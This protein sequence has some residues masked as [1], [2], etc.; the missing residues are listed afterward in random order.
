MSLQKLYSYARLV[1]FI[2]AFILIHGC[3]TIVYRSIPLKDIARTGGDYAVGTQYFY[4]VDST[5]SM[6]LDDDIA[7][8]RE[9]S[10]KIWYPA[11][12]SQLRE[13][14]PYVN[15]Q[16]LISEALSVRLGV[17]KAL[18]KRAGGVECNSWLDAVPVRGRFPIVIYSH[19]HQSLKIANTFQAEEL[20][21]NGFIVIAPDHTY[22]AAVTI[23]KNESVIYSKSRLM[24][25]NQQSSERELTEV[26][27]KQ[28]K[29]RTDDIRF[30][31]D[32]VFQ[33][34]SSEIEFAGTADTSRVGIF[35]HSFGG[36]TSVASAYNDNRI[37]AVFGLD[38]Y[39]LPLSENMISKDLNKPFAHLGQPSWGSS[40]NYAVMEALAKKNSKL[41][42]HFAAQGSKHYDFTDFSQFTRLTKKFG[43][44]KINPK[45]IRIIMNTLLL[46]FFNATLKPGKKFNPQLYEQMFPEITQYIY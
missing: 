39:F 17:P 27:D 40:N 23:L 45:T 1:F 15:H 7:G 36:C 9:L 41:S 32:K 19:G 13:K 38:T 21:S 10:V 20:A 34:L 16:D 11:D 18:M 3:A 25:N 46:D 44:G 31:I 5:R 33:K 37:D 4:L 26:V 24:N 29:I 12:D 8:H 6:W 35:G 43:S 22:D 14:A 28:L 42:T 30:L 2:P